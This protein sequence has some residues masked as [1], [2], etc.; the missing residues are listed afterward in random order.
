MTFV[1]DAS[2]ALSWLLEDAGADQAYANSIFNSMKKPTAQ[3]QVPAIWGLEI[4]NVIAKSESRG[5]L[6]A[7]R[8]QA[9]LNTLS[10]LPI[11]CDFQTHA[12]AL[13]NTLQLS[14]QHHLSAYDASYLEL[15]MR[16][17]LPIATLDGNLAKAALKGGVARVAPASKRS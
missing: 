1:L 2:V 9:F 3:A 11:V 14:R 8:S 13:N 4:A 7:S 10:A 6:L 5:L 12:N 15:A 17:G 16:L